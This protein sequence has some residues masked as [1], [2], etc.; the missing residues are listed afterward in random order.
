MALTSKIRPTPEAVAV[1]SLGGSEMP[2]GAPRR[3][4][5]ATGQRAP[6]SSDVTPPGR[7]TVVG[8]G[9]G[10]LLARGRP[11]AA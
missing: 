9:A 5:G 6:L 10:T 11:S 7:L 3:S 4:A 8:S 1:R 2:S